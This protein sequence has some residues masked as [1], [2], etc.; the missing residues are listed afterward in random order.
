MKKNCLPKN[1]ALPCTALVTGASS[2]MGLAYARELAAAGCQVLMVSNQEL[3]LQQLAVSIQQEFH[4][5]VWPKFCDLAREEAAD[6]LFRYC[7]EMGLEIDILI[8]NA[9]IF[10]FREL[11]EEMRAPMDLMMNLHMV[12][13]TRLCFLFGNQMKLRG[14]G[15]IL[16]V[17]SVAAGM[18]VPGLTMYAA[19]KSYLRSFSKSLYFEMRP[20]GVGV[21][22][23]CP[24][25][26]DTGLYHV[27]PGLV[28]ILKVAGKFGLVYSPE[29]LVRKALRAMFHRRRCV[30][31]GLLNPLFGPTVNALPNFLVHRIW[32]KL[33]S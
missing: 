12:T 8:N 19:T 26:V 25:A 28:R 30:T 32:K 21:T 3:E 2:G 9:G 10:F 6:E 22:V 27:L 5:N 1:F 24:G 29:K 16:N 15:F 20:Y 18:P 4:V 14:R 31:P 13:P 33:H 17:S 7:Q 11:Q 23:V